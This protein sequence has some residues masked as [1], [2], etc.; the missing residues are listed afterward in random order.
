MYPSFNHQRCR[1][2]LQEDPDTKLCNYK[3][4]DAPLGEGID[5]FRVVLPFKRGVD[6]ETFDRLVPALEK[7]SQG[8][9]AAESYRPN[10]IYYVYGWNHEPIPHTAVHHKG[11]LLDWTQLPLADIPPEPSPDGLRAVNFDNLEPWKGEGSFGEIEL[12]S[13]DITQFFHDQG[14][15]V[16][17]SSIGTW[18]RCRCFLGDWHSGD[19]KTAY[20]MHDATGW[21][22]KCHHST[23]GGVGELNHRA[24]IQHFGINTIKPYCLHRKSGT[25]LKLVTKRKKIEKLATPP[26]EVSTDLLV[27][28]ETISWF[29]LN[30]RY[31]PQE[32]F[33]VKPGITLY[34]SDKDTGKTVGL[35]RLSEQFKKSRLS[36]IVIGHRVSLLADLA[37]KMKVANYKDTTTAKQI[38]VCLDSITK[39]S[40]LTPFEVV[41][42]D[43]IEQVLMHCVS[44]TF[45]KSRDKV[46][47]KFFEIITQAEQIYVSDADI[48][49]LTLEFLDLL[50]HKKADD[51]VIYLNDYSVHKNLTLFES[52]HEF[53]EL[54]LDSLGS[55]KRCYFASNSQGRTEKMEMLLANAVPGINMIRIDS[56]TI[57]SAPQQEWLSKVRNKLPTDYQCVLASPAVST[58]IDIQEP[59]DM[60]FGWFEQNVNT[61]FEMSQQLARVRNCK[62]LYVFVS[63]RK[64]WM[65]TDKIL[66]KGQ[67][68]HT[69]RFRN[70][71]MV[72]DIKLQPWERKYRI[73]CSHIESMVN[74]SM[75]DLVGNFLRYAE[76][77]KWNI[78]VIP[79]P[80]EVNK[81]LF[82][83]SDQA[84]QAI[85]DAFYEDVAAARILDDTEY[86]E[87]MAHNSHLKPE[88]KVFTTKYQIMKF[89]P[90]ALEAVTAEF[91]KQDQEGLR[92]LVDNYRTY[93]MSED[94]LK[95]LEHND[96]YRNEI[97]RKNLWQRQLKLKEILGTIGL[98]ELDTTVEITK[99]QCGPFIEFCSLRSTKNR[100]EELFKRTMYSNIA[101][102]PIKQLK[103]ILELSG[104]K[105]GPPLRKRVNGKVVRY[106]KID[107]LMLTDMQKLAN[108]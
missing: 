28:D 75:N 3:K 79:K 106:Y 82:K 11:E 60:V 5:R 29:E 15:L 41:V 98:A 43:E 97:D 34:K 12:N 22:F 49:L 19:D 10:A 52:S 27:W 65:R 6:V 16:E 21:R 1:Y 55:G 108:K 38:A 17:S 70:R 71:L 74:A 76:S 30:D 18:N 96:R 72:W 56:T 62:D 99:D 35:T 13:F 61:H 100:Y 8:K 81:E 44:D 77:K 102:E 20:F 14:L 9:P 94:Q 68:E 86:Y 50:R 58:G 48:S 39:V 54:L 83:E 88:E 92:R 67:K 26:Q 32:A 23:H 66:I 90:I 103:K 40:P 46:I 64:N 104:V 73:L 69:E 45:R 78:T 25:E 4:V 85:K 59:Y 51:T 80:D 93:T 37:H 101:D 53:T 105:L 89:Y 91:V 31:L 84:A 107:P 42:I 47:S 7:L 87:L 33:K 36:V 95:V 63:N 2:R 24:L 57:E